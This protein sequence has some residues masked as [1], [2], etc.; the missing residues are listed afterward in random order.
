MGKYII[1]KE[2]DK[3]VV[4]EKKIID[5]KIGVLVETLTGSKETRNVF[6]PNVKVEREPF[7]R[8]EREGQVDGTKGVFT[9]GLLDSYT[10]FKPAKDGSRKDN[11]EVAYQESNGR[12][13]GSSSNDW[14]SSPSVVQK[15]KTGGWKFPNWLS[16]HFGGIIF[17]AAS[18]GALYSGMWGMEYVTKFSLVWWLCLVLVVASIPGVIVGILYALGITVVVLALWV[19]VELIKHRFSRKFNRHIDIRFS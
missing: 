9:K 6:G 15:S 2:G 16:E 3:E 13:V 17:A 8:R 10:T 12:S 11:A 4:H 1:K 18:Y 14:T 5:R 7:L 19:I